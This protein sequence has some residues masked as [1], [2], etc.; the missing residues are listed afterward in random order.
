MKLSFFFLQLM[1]VFCIVQIAPAPGDGAIHVSRSI[2][3]DTPFLLIS[4]VMLIQFI[5]ARRGW[6][7][8]TISGSFQ[9]GPSLNKSILK[10]SQVFSFIPRQM[11]SVLGLLG[12]IF[13][14]FNINF[15]LN[16]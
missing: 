16:S 3:S 13:L 15:L 9:F 14:D 12:R 7:Q 8:I 6:H 1:N 10:V 11:L 4:S 2:L 5:P